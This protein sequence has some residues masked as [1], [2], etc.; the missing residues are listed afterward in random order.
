MIHTNLLIVSLIFFPLFSLSKNFTG[1]LAGKIGRVTIFRNSYYP[2][3]GVLKKNMNIGHDDT[4]LTGP[5][6][7]ALIRFTGNIPV[8]M[9]A[10]TS[11]SI[12]RIKGYDKDSIVYHGKEKRESP[13][14]IFIHLNYGTIRLYSERIFVSTPLVFIRTL[15]GNIMVSHS[16]CE[17]YSEIIT[18]SGRARVSKTLEISRN[19]MLKPFRR[20]II[21]P[22][23]AE[24]VVSLTDFKPAILNE[25]AREKFEA[26]FNRTILYEK[27]YDSSFIDRIFRKILL[28]L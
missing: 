5:E 4:L 8:F 7:E 28:Y 19:L 13:Y 17:N 18:L 12:K 11:I 20:L 1:Y 22:P 2:T 14:K 16:S 26:I 15:K 25:T 27:H 6:G 24:K 23:G 21:H 9:G 3:T 10:D